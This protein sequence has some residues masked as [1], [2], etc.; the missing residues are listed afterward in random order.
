[1][2]RLCSYILCVLLLISVM[3][4][5]ADD[6]FAVTLNVA[7]AELENKT[8]ITVTTTGGT[9]EYVTLLVNG[10]EV[11]TQKTGDGGTYTFAYWYDAVGTYQLRAIASDGT[12]A[13]SAD[14]TVKVV[15]TVVTQ[16]TLIDF[17][18][19]T[20]G[21]SVGGKVV[22]RSFNGNCT[23]APKTFADGHG[24]TFFVTLGDEMQYTGGPQMGYDRL[25][26]NEINIK[27]DVRFNWNKGG[28]SSKYA[29]Y[30]QVM[31]YDE[32]GSERIDWTSFVIDNGTLN[33]G[34]TTYDTVEDQWYTFSYTVNP[35]TDKH[36]LTV[37][38]DNQVV[39][40]Y[41][42][43]AVGG[44]TKTTKKQQAISAFSYLRFWFKGGNGE[45]YAFDNFVSSVS[46]ET[47]QITGVAA[48][49]SED[50]SKVLPYTA[51]CVYVGL[52]DGF[53]SIT[54]DD[55]TLENEIGNV[56]IKDVDLANGK[57]KIV[58][59][60]AGQKFETSNRYR[61]TVGKNAGLKDEKTLG[62]NVMYCF[63]TTSA[64]IDLKEGKF[65]QWG[66]N[67]K[68]TPEFSG[69]A[70]AKIVL[71]AFENGV[72]ASVKQ[73]DS[74]D[75]TVSDSYASGTVLKAIAVGNDLKP[76]SNKVYQYTVK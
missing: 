36:S 13:V 3:P 28:T 66:S 24:N 15:R 26:T 39:L 63:T 20:G 14:K 16:D 33:A 53:Q 52:A 5:F 69:S 17:E 74:A 48:S 57:L 34:G 68:F 45:T 46:S 51:D 30:V 7:D 47:P 64:S 19:Y 23:I 49:E 76:I 1:M 37:T 70:E 11:E 55:I 2:K 56:K 6:G 72:F 75:N 59:D 61:I 43:V 67:V 4:V 29:P 73:S 12:K 40:S 10:Q 21:G 58:P 54:K 71:L 35:K 27:F 8:P 60:V 44:I 38:L 65:E 31:G 25:S 41:S 50:V 9:A 18:D 42:N 32:T 22:S 62:C